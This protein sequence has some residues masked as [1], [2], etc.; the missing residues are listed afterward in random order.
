M[1]AIIVFILLATQCFLI[2]DVSK[3]AVSDTVDLQHL[4]RNGDDWTVFRA[5][6]NVEVSTVTLHADKWL[7]YFLHWR[8]L[9]DKN[10]NLSIEY[11]KKLLLSFWGPDMPFRIVGQGG[12]T[13]VGGHPAFYIDGTIYNNKIRT[14]FIVWNCDQ[15]GRQ[16]I[17]DC[18]INKSLGTQDKFLHTQYKITSTIACHGNAV[19]NNHSELSRHYHSRR[20][21]LSFF[22]PA[23]W[24]TRPFQS[25]KWFP[26][27]MS[28]SNGTLWTL[29]TDSQKVIRWTT[30]RAKPRL[31]TAILKDRILSLKGKPWPTGINGIEAK[32][33]RV[34]LNGTSRTDNQVWGSG[35]LT[36]QFEYQK[37]KYTSEYLFKAGLWNQKKGNFLLC[38]FAVMKE[39]WQQPFDLSPRESELD[40]WFRRGILPALKNN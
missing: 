27:G 30:T 32:I 17:A 4:S 11:V 7:M 22:T 37:K 28:I 40:G 16:F 12:E 9:T 3:S 39:V 15:T 34:D 14:R 6:R 33:V 8:P 26:Q 25:K 19:T 20:Y 18:N 24:R 35:R 23:L 10:R 31:S 2:G 36:A 29:V 38:A 1:K 5:Q 13:T 21:K